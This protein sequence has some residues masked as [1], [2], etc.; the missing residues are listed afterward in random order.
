MAG[1]AGI[2]ALQGGGHLNGGPIQPKG[3]PNQQFDA[4]FLELL[5]GFLVNAK[6][7]NPDYVVCDYPD[8]TKLQSCC[9]PSG[10][11]YVSV[12]RMV[13]AMAEWIVARGPT[14]PG[15]DVN[16]LDVLVSIYRN[17]FDPK[18][19]DFWG[20]ARSDKATQL[21]VEAALIASTRIR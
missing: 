4:Y 17:A 3:P 16:L 2:A 1:V 13:P 6:R 18:Y 19:P 14:V 21:S 10:K 5:G 7:T 11:S 8:G 9:T 20:L 12:A 15:S